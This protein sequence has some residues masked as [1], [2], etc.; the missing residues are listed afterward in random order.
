MTTVAAPIGEASD[1]FRFAAAVAAFGMLLRE[2]TD[3]GTA[4][5][6]LAQSL[7]REALGKDPNAY[8]AEF[9][10]LIAMAQSLG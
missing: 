4:S 9:L 1:D 10:R 8:R 5:Y 3:R 7:A 6:D 2:S